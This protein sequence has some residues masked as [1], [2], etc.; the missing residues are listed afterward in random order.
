MSEEAVTHLKEGG[1]GKNFLYFLRTYIMASGLDFVVD[2]STE[3]LK[4][5][6]IMG[7]LKN[8]QNTLADRQIIEAT[9]EAVDVIHARRE[10]SIRKLVMEGW[11]VIEYDE[12]GLVDI[13]VD[14][15]DGSLNFLK[16]QG[17]FGLPYSFVAY[18]MPRDAKVIS[19]VISTIVVDLRCGDTWYASQWF[20]QFEGICNDGPLSV[21]ETAIKIDGQHIYGGEFYYPRNRELMCKI[22]GDQKGW[23]RNPG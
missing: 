7:D 22:A 4:V 23:F 13:Y 8:D 6:T 1:R 17:T 5:G 12:D 19:D 18:L 2:V 15:L 10:V 9:I 21:D 20:E 11:P 16:K 14:P 3:D